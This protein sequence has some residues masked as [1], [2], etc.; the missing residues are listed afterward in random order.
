MADADTETARAPETPTPP[1]EGVR[2]IYRALVLFASCIKSGEDWSSACEKARTEALEALAALERGEP[3]NQGARAV[4]KEGFEPFVPCVLT[5]DE[6]P[7]YECVVA[8]APTVT[9]EIA[10]NVDLLLSMDDRETIIGLRVFKTPTHPASSGAPGVEEVAAIISPSAFATIY[11]GAPKHAEREHNRERA[12]A[13][14]RK[15]LALFPTLPQ[16]TAAGAT[17]KGVWIDE[18]GDRYLDLTTPA[19]PDREAV[20]RIKSAI[21]DLRVAAIPTKCEVFVM[22]GAPAQQL[23]DDLEGILS[24]R[25]APGDQDHSPRAVP[26][27]AEGE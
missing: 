11:T 26:L 19:V 23:A 17:T 13:K 4:S 2:A 5:L 16:P 9:R 24:Q 15:I 20:V 6:P 10:P 1:V 27:S 14:A 12:R 25:P 8:D 3:G 22:G 21:E 18:V 7:R